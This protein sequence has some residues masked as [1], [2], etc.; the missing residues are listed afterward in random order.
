M[1][2][3]QAM[4]ASFLMCKNFE[5]STNFGNKLKFLFNSSYFY[6]FYLVFIS[7]F[8]FYGAYIG[9]FTAYNHESSFRSNSLIEIATNSKNTG[10]CSNKIDDYGK[11]AIQ[12]SQKFNGY[13]NYFKDQVMLYGVLNKTDY[14]V[15]DWHLCASNQIIL[16]NKA[17]VELLN[18]HIN[19]LSTISILPGKLGENTR[20][21]TQKYLDLWEN[22]LLLLLSLAPKR[23]D[24]ATPLIAYY[25]NKGNDN[26]IIRICKNLSKSDYYQG[27]C[28]LALGAIAIKEG[29]LNQGLFLIKKARDLGVLDSEDIDKET[30]DYLK[31][32][33]KEYGK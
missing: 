9:F 8:L 30:A 1:F 33:L 20:L 7:L 22:K 29:R 13:N 17:S 25:L 6:S 2:T 12:Y 27:Y 18:V 31:N 28:D 23:V 14:E 11:G 5:L 15:L 21:L 26:G 24:Q 19:V 16:A 4:L 32:I 10:L 3:F